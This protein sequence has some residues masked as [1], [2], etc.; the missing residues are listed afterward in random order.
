LPLNSFTKDS[1]V[2][3]DDIKDNIFPDKTVDEVHALVKEYA[4]VLQH[5]ASQAWGWQELSEHLASLG[6]AGDTDLAAWG[7]VWKAEQ[8]NAHATLVGA[9]VWNN[10]YQSVNW[11]VDLLSAGSSSQQHKAGEEAALL[12]PVALVQLKVRQSASPFRD[13]A[14]FSLLRLVPVHSNHTT[15]VSGARRCRCAVNAAVRA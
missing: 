10:T 7:K 6:V 12:E 11:R 15:F 4:A 5:A 13:A 8:A 2:T 1:G 9:S 14:T 3:V